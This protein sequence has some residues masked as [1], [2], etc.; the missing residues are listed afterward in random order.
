VKAGCDLNCGCTYEHLPAAVAQGLVSEAE[1]DHCLE[2]LFSARFRLGMFDPPERV[3]YAQI[4]YEVNDCERHAELALVAARESL[5][6]LKN[7]SELLPLARDTKSIAVIGPNADDPK[8]LVGNYHGTPSRSV[9]PLAGIRAAVAPEIKVWYAEGCKRSGVESDVPH[10]AALLSEAKSMAERAEVVVLCLGLDAEI[11]GEEGDAASSEA[12]GDKRS[13]ALPGLQEQ[14]FETV[15]ATGKPIVVVLLSGSP[16]AVGFAHERAGALLQAFYPGQAG[17]RALADV[18]FGNY[19]P[20][21]RLPVTFPRSLADVPAFESYAMRGRTYRY[22]ESEPLY[23]FGFGLSYARFA[24]SALA[25]SRT[26]LTQEHDTVD[27]TVQV[28]NTGSRTSDEVVELY[29]KALDASGSAPHH[30]LRGFERITLAAAESRRVS[31]TLTAR[32]FSLIDDEGRR[33]LVPGRYRVTVGGS[34]PDARSVAL[35]GEAPLAAEL[36]LAGARR[37]I[38]Y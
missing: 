14:L 37:E 23:P 21:G 35:L 6:L 12:S 2:R 25:L 28:T 33:V 38:P 4:P 1:L 5:V 26:R 13:L 8:V 18:L 20:A 30:E 19:S 34:Q 11:E 29:V 36:E 24:Y 15:A 32:D 7:E 3:P 16:L 10:R 17:G 27:V 22:L 9:T 31:F